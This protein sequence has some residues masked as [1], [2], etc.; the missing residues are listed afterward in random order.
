MDIS[1]RYLI[2]VCFAVFFVCCRVVY[3]GSSVGPPGNEIQVGTSTLESPTKFTG[4]NGIVVTKVGTDTVNMAIG[5]GAFAGMSIVGT[6]S[7]IGSLGTIPDDNSLPESTEG[8]EVFTVTYTPTDANNLIFVEAV[9]NV[10]GGNI[11]DAACIAAIFLNSGTQTIGANR[12]MG[13]A[14]SGN[15]ADRI[16]TVAAPPFIAGTTTPFTVRLRCGVGGGTGRLNASALDG[17]TR[18]PGAWYSYLKVMEF[19]P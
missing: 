12:A 1:R 17:L 13:G 2:C 19:K 10:S 7:V 9:A 4:S 16:I 3:S 15:N 14:S 11:G 5:S 8:T 18:F 6:T